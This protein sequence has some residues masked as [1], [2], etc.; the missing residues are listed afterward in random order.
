MAHFSIAHILRLRDGMYAVRSAEYPG[1]EGR[2]FQM[3]PAREKF[4]AALSE[5]VREII[6]QGELPPSLYPSLEEAESRFGAQC[7]T[8]IPAEDRLPKTYD[9]AV[10][11]EVDLPA[12][13]A[14]RFAAIRIGKLLPESRL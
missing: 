4:R 13:E 12:E 14:E 11:V 9:Y 1:C 6:D 10:I 2:D 3:W 8:Q 5:Q 7:K